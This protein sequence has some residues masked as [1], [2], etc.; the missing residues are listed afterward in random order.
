MTRFADSGSIPGEP[1]VMFSGHISRV[2]RLA[3]VHSPRALVATCNE[4]IVQKNARHALRMSMNPTARAE[5]SLETVLSFTEIKCPCH[6]EG[7]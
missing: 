1:G 6:L 7:A 4:P 5:V 2:P 3:S